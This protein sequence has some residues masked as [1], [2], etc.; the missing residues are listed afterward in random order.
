MPNL[1]L[2]SVRDNCVQDK[3]GLNWGF[4]SGHVCIADAYIALT[5]EFFRYN[6][7]FFPGHGSTI[8]TRWDDGREIVCLLEGTQF[9]EGSIY[10]KQIS[11]YED[12][13]ELGYYLRGRLGV[14]D[15]HHISM[16]DLENYGRD[17]V[18]VSHI[19]DNIYYF[20]FSV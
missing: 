16:E 9:I 18:S 2:Y 8:I 19:E 3:A 12:K 11:S 1:E 13:S 15:T 5:T 4:S 17:F 6:I 14:S 20:D 10:P 7:N